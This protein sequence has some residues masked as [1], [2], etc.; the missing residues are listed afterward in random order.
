MKNLHTHLY[1]IY[2][3]D[4]LVYVGITTREITIRWQEH[5]LGLTSKFI[6]NIVKKHGPNVLKFYHIISFFT[7]TAFLDAKN[8][9]I[10][11]IAKFRNKGIKL[12]NQTDGGDGALGYKHPAGMFAGPNNP[13][14]GKKHSE[15]SI[16]K[17]RNAR[18][19]KK[20]SVESNKKRSETLSGSNNPFFGKKHS[21]ET[22]KKIS[23]KNKGK[24]ASNELKK[25]LSISQKLSYEK[26]RQNGT[27]KQS[28]LKGK[29]RS[30]E[31]IE[32]YKKTRQQMKESGYKQA[33]HS[34]ESNKKRSESLKRTFKL[35]REL[36]LLEA[37]E[38]VKS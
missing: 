7:K 16:E 27:I 13:F 22:K 3:N 25:K 5:K 8:E 12:F 10:S 33:S 23:K 38:N 37:K 19:G 11:Q 24:K 30:Q 21:E 34:E 35:K 29:K 31:S 36:Q 1:H 20:Q 15:E 26:K 32:K 28:P 17:M 6:R 9:E 2:Y 14:F 18:K 4:K